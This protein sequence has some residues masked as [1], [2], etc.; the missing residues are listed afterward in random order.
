MFL[1]EVQGWAHSEQSTHPGGS[2]PSTSPL[3]IFCD[4]GTETAHNMLHLCLLDSIKHWR[5]T[6]RQR[7]PTLPVGLLSW[8][9]HPNNGPQAVTAAITGS[10]FHTPQASRIT[11][12]L[13]GANR[14]QVTTSPQR[15][16]SQLPGG[17]LLS[18]AT[19]GFPPL[20]DLTSS[21]LEAVSRATDSHCPR[22]LCVVPQP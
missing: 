9:C 13:W 4:A 7:D 21:C 5:K 17:P 20:R 19:G 1:R 12:S 22:H 3:S 6:E 11:P 16:K 15:I 10:S 2:A 14:T 18:C 8:Q